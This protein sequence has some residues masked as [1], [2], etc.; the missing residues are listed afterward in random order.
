MHWLALGCLCAATYHNTVVSTD[1]PPPIVI[2]EVHSK[3]LPEILSV[4][5]NLARARFA[6]RASQADASCK[7]SGMKWDKGALLEP[8]VHLLLPCLQCAVG[9]S[10]KCDKTRDL[11]V[12]VSTLSFM[13]LRGNGPPGPILWYSRLKG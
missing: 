4:A 2:H 3:M 13:A 6:A 5:A 10:G 11:Y 9:A 1:L 7:G 8:Q 12:A